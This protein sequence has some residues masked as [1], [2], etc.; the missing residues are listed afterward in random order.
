MQGY[1]SI[2]FTRRPN[3][4]LLSERICAEGIKCALGSGKETKK[5]GLINPA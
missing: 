5:A 3:K 2:G 1:F 4:A